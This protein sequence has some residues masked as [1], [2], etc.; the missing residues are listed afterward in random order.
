MARAIDIHVEH[1]TRVEGHGDIFFNAREGKVEKVQWHVTEAPRFF[2]AM[3]RGKSY[4]H[5]Q[6]ITSRICGICSIGHSLA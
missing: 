6:P 5:L 3:L 1:L 4:V 2:E